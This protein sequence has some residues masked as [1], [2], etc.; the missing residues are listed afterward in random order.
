MLSD[1][2][3]RFSS[4]VTDYVRYRPSYPA[5]IITLLET[6]CALTPASIVSDIGSGPGLLAELFLKYGCEV[7]C[8]EPNVEMRTAGEKLLAGFGRFRSVNGRAEES[9]LADASVDLITAGQAFH[10]FDPVLSR[11]EFRRVL[12]PPASVVLV[13]NE[14]LASG[15][16][17]L[18]GY[19]SLLHTYAPDYGR[20]DHRQVDGKA[21]DAFFGGG[22]WKLH[23]LPNE[24]VFDFEGVIGRL[25][26]SSYAPQPGAAGYHAMVR[27]L[28]LLFDRSHSGGLV[29]FLYETKVYSGRWTRDRSGPRISRTTCE[30]GIGFAPCVRF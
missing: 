30:T 25:H 7:W 28:K 2:T 5:E 15:D 4:R 13:W 26:S 16:P 8:V 21:M 23:T 24:Q 22:R 9:R 17:F 6:D 10:W 19:E 27:E 14:R 1:P 11:R 3:L 29:R 20:V 18:E 12:R